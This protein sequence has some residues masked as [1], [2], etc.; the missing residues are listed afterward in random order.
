[1]PEET[2]FLK[3]LNIPNQSNFFTQADFSLLAESMIDQAVLRPL[4]TGSNIP[5]LYTY[6]GQWFDH[7]VTLENQ[8]SLTNLT[9]VDAATLINGKTSWIELDSLYG[10][11]G[12]LLDPDG[13]FPIALNANNVLDLPR[14]Q[15]TGQAII[16]DARNNENHIVGHIHLAFLEL[17]NKILDEVKLGNPTWTLTQQIDEAKKQVVYIVQWILAHDFLEHVCSKYYS[18]LWNA[19]G[20]PNI[21]A[22]ILKTGNAMSLEFVIAYRFGHSMVRPN[23]YVNSS[24]D[25][26]NIFGADVGVLNPPFQP[27]DLSGFRAFPANTG[28]DWSFWVELEGFK[29]PQVAEKIDGGIALPLATLPTNVI[30]P[31]GGPTTLHERTLLRSHFIYGLAGGQDLAR[32]MGISESEIISGA[33][34]NLVLKNNNTLAPTLDMVR[35]NNLFADNTP[36]FLYILKEAEVFCQGESL[37][38]LGTILI[39]CSFLHFIKNTPG[40]NIFTDNWT[41]V[42]GKYGCVQNG[43]YDMKALI[44]Y[45]HGFPLTSYANIPVVTP[46]TRLFDQH[47]NVQGQLATQNQVLHS[48]APLVVGALPDIGLFYTSPNKFFPTLPIPAILFGIVEVP[49]VIVPPPTPEQIADAQVIVNQVVDNANRRNIRTDLAVFTF[50]INCAILS[51]AQG[52]AIPV[53]KPIVYPAIA[54][55][56]NL[57]SLY[58]FTIKDVNG[59]VVYSKNFIARNGETNNINIIADLSKV[60]AI[61]PLT[62]ELK[63]LDNSTFLSGINGIVYTV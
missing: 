53:D 9:L 62:Y 35:L 7:E 8:T 59:V 34:G 39:G 60:N 15:T 48:L 18:R 56:F 21:N 41:P 20:T 31:N 24:F 37:G 49:G 17:H 1:M 30:G 58:A 33:K 16:G 57:F 11:N 45:I 46:S 25:V 40:P 55:W 50:V 23:Y 3:I 10:P 38:P 22:E 47:S 29:G 61:G 28:L 42:A 43:V 2:S 13:K 26:L 19:D 32:I 12:S 36:L 4:T 44:S 27:F 63:T 6:L 51:I 52:F 54:A 14:D 5:A